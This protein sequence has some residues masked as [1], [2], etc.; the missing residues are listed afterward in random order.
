M[1]ERTI[2]V[3]IKTSTP[4]LGRIEDLEFRHRLEKGLSAAVAPAGYYCDGGQSGSGT[5]EVFLN[6]Q[7]HGADYAAALAAVKS[8]LDEAKLFSRCAIGE[9]CPDEN[10]SVVLWPEA[11]KG[12]TFNS[13]RW[14]G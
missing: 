10:R 1:P 14:N 12:R 13:F 9:I 3:Q 2:V 7:R 6:V 8:Y 4:D 5:M 11:A